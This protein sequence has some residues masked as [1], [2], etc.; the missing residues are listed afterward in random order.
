MKTTVFAVALT[1]AS[2]ASGQTAQAAA[3]DLDPTFGTGGQVTTDFNHST[4]I[5]N[6]VALQSDGKLVVAGTTFKN[7]DSTSEDFAIIRYNV[8]GTL[9]T[10]FGANGKVRTDFPGLAAVASSVLVQPDGKIL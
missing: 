6:A 8:D 2:W 7:N 9:D 5:A 1:L 4:D 3:G 10:T